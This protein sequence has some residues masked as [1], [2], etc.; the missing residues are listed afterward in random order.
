M[1]IVNM[2]KV[3][4]SAYS[5]SSNSSGLILSCRNFTTWF[6]RQLSPKRCT[7]FSWSFVDQVF[8]I[9]LLQRAIF[10]NLKITQTLKYLETHLFKKISAQC[11]EDHIQISWKKFFFEKNFFQGLG[12]FFVIAK[13][14]IWASF[15]STQNLFYN[16]F[17]V[18]LFDFIIVLK[19]CFK[20]LFRKTVKNWWF[21]SFK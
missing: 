16:F 18:W 3:I 2:K 20:N 9:I 1:T 5:K 12:A 7:E 6:V 15:F 14:L 11:F 4:T 17:Q 21:Y 8:L 13:P 19:T 10:R